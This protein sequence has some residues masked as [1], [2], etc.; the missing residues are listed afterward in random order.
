MFIGK[1][2]GS[3]WATRKTDNTTGV[4]FLI[5]QPFNLNKKPNTDTV[6]VADVLGAGE[7]EYVMCAYGRAARLAVGDEN[8]SIEAA[9][10]AIIDEYEVSAK[11]YTGDL[12]PDKATY[13]KRHQ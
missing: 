3:L 13:Q 2:V 9:V 10:T 6:V 8:M 11:H 4:K 1:V 7:G 5:V 12:D